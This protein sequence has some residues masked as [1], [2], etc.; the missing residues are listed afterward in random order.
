MNSGLNV[1][2]KPNIKDTISGAV[3]RFKVETR[4]ETMHASAELVKLKAENPIAFDYQ[5]NRL[6]GMD[7]GEAVK[8]AYN[9]NGKPYLR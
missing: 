6:Q 4:P 9:N 8:S 1:S 2:Q 5:V 3:K 7:K